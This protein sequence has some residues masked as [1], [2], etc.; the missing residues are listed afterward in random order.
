M[1]GGAEKTP[2]ELGWRMP[3]EWERQEAVWFIWPHRENSWPGKLD[4]A[5][6]AYARIAAAIAP[7]QTVRMI[8]QDETMRAEAAQMMAEAGAPLSNVELPVFQTDDSWIRDCGPIFVVRETGDGGREVAVTDWVFNTWGDKYPPYD[9]D[10]LV[11]GWIA[12]MHGLAR[13]VEDTVLEGGSIDT[14][15][16]GVLLTTGQCLLNPNRNP[17]LSRADIE[18]KL[19]AMLGFTDII[20]LGDGVIGDDTDGHVDDLSRFVDETTIVTAVEHDPEDAN[21]GPLRDNLEL[22]RAARTPSGEPYTIIEL[23][24]PDPVIYQGE[25]LP[26]TY[27]NFLI[28][29]EV[30]VMPSFACPADDVAAGILQR[31]FPDRRVV[32]VDCRELVWGLGAVHCISCHQPAGW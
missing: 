17:H 31:C 11:P 20:W 6:R 5:R 15:G 32:A 29:N 12:T 1:S 26:A 8:V 30:V 28:T 10:N 19:R 24:M 27:A 22:L 2:A 18:A 21:H 16:A 23:P 14:N 9:R 25:Q 13:F 4:A 3:A 7:T